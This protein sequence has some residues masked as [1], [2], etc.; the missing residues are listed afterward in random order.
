[1]LAKNQQQI[2]TCFMWLVTPIVTSPCVSSLIPRPFLHQR[3]TRS[4]LGRDTHTCTATHVHCIHVNHKHMLRTYTQSHCLLSSFYP[5]ECSQHL[6]AHNA[7]TGHIHCMSPS[8]R[9]RVPARLSFF[10]PHLISLGTSA[11]LCWHTP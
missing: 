8:P 11:R 3:N 2:A 10:S 7:H 9:N 4:S 6:F 1:M 5:A